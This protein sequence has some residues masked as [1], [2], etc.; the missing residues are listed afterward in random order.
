MIGG[1]F[2]HIIAEMKWVIDSVEWALFAR[3]TRS[4][5]LAFCILAADPI[6]AI[7]RSFVAPRLHPYCLRFLNDRLLPCQNKGHLRRACWG[8]SQISLSASASIGAFPA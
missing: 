6:D 3:I 2:T 8:E 4:E 7:L 1:V 5:N